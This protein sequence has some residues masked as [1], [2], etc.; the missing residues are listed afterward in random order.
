MNEVSWLGPQ[1]LALHLRRLLDY[2]VQLG[3]LLVL[4]LSAYFYLF[5][6]PRFDYWDVVYYGSFVVNDDILDWKVL[7]LYLLDPVVESF[8][9]V[10]KLVILLS[11]FFGSAVYKVELGF[12]FLVFFSGYLA[13]LKIFTLPL[14]PKGST[15]L[16]DLI[17]L[18]IVFC[19]YWWPVSIPTYTNTWFSIQYSLTVTMG[20]WT[21]YFSS[22]THWS[23]KR[24]MLLMVCWIG[25]ALSHGTGLLLGLVLFFVLLMRQGARWLAFLILFI[26]LAMLMLSKG[27]YGDKIGALDQIAWSSLATWNYLIRI[28]TPSFWEKLL[29]VL[30]I[31]P[32]VFLGLLSLVQ[33]P[34]KFFNTPPNLLIAWGMVVWFAT[35]ITRAGDQIHGN[36][37]YFKFYVVVYIAWLITLVDMRYVVRA[38]SSKKTAMVAVILLAVIWIKGVENGVVS[39]R[40]FY[41]DNQ[42]GYRALIQEQTV[43]MGDILLL[44]PN[45]RLTEK[46]V[47]RLKSYPLYSY[48]ETLRN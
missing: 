5:Q 1:S 18:T 10:P 40:N 26:M 24:G 6:I 11:N 47:P 23:T 32:C 17:K 38:V 28:I 39:A 8:M 44:Y 16:P 25:S 27:I 31:V 20:L 45:K 7:F 4:V 21:V 33:N 42:K 36:P 12:S 43:E 14:V 9:L 29:F 2:R 3:Y 13:L 15:A 34:R 37:H 46:I 19:F 41:I 22:S 48:T 30:F 35:F